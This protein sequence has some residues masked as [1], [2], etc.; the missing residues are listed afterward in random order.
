MSYNKKGYYKRA[1]KIQ[2]IAKEFYE[3]GRQDRCY[4]WVWRYHVLPVYG[5]QYRAFLTYLK[6][7]IPDD[8]ERHQSYGRQPSLFDDI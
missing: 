7:E 4:K 1:Q 2:Q 8:L 6:V 3:P 5:I